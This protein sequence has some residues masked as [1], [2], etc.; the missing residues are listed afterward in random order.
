MIRVAFIVST[1]DSGWLGAVNYIANLC[2]CVM[3]L[4]DR[5]IE[6]VVFVGPKTPQPLL[7]GFANVTIVRTPFVG[8]RQPVRLA[9][10]AVERITGRNLVLELYL[11]TYGIRVL[12][13]SGT[14]GW[15]SSV[16]AVTWIPDFQ[17]MHLPE[18]F[19]TQEIHRRDV[20]YR[21]L[22]RQ[23]KI[24]ILSSRDAQNDFAVFEPSCL[25][26]S[27]VLNFVSGLGSS[28]KEPSET[29]L[30]AKYE[31]D[32]PY[33]YLPNQFWKH[34]NHRV[35]IEALATL[36]AHGEPMLVLATGLMRDTRAPGYAGEV[37]GLVANLGV[38]D[39]FRPLGLVP[40]A[41]VLALCRH[42]L[43]IINP[44]LFEGW[45]SSVEE[46]KSMGK[47]VLLSDIPVH[48]EQA[49]ERGIYFSPHD[50]Q[51][52]ANSMHEAAAIASPE[53]DAA[54]LA[55]AERVRPVRVAAFAR[56]YQK[57]VLEA[58]GC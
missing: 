11:R 33:F 17:H 32:R 51:A 54:F 23:S 49:P 4:P 37:T 35:V 21:K 18:L 34:K 30:R 9:G 24:V 8:R 1:T 13:H 6:P 31:I 44:S 36:R 53:S 15:Y 50:A 48:K 7:A 42:S 47:I 5:E 57:I 22:V 43:A 45:S 38:S 39:D 19:S 46:G 56:Q 16:P 41:D 27:R 2:Q 55:R 52:L 29:Q 26:R 58:A 40:Y 20:E 3:A 12:S 28:E 14:L 10:K 25:T